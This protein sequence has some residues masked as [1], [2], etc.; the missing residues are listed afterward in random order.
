MKPPKPLSPRRARFVE[1]YL[2]DLN[3][4]RAA[5]RA[6][7]PPRTANVRAA[8]LLAIRSVRAAVDE[9][10]ARRAARAEVKQDDVLRELMRIAQSDPADAFNDDGSLKPM[11]DMSVETRRAI[12][13]V[14]TDEL[15]GGVGE[16]RA[17]IGITRKVK[18]WPK[19]Q[20]LEALGRHL[21]MFTDKSEV[22]G[23]DGGDLVVRV[24]TE[25]ADDA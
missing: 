2:I 22:T 4:A 5:I 18:F 14:E 1:E 11:R 16:D 3:G 7:Y 13:S 8:Q 23:K 15:W 25:A 19:T 21:K 9:A 12:A 20:A 24:V 10:I 6:G 17:Q